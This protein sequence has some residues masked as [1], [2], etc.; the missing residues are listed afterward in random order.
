M[1]YC[2]RS[3]V[4][5]ILF[6]TLSAG[7]RTKTKDN[8]HK[9]GFEPIATGTTLPLER[10]TLAIMDHPQRLVRFIGNRRFAKTLHQCREEDSLVWSVRSFGWEDAGSDAEA[11]TL[12]SLVG[13]RDGEEERK[14][15]T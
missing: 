14:A 13:L 2:Q 5:S 12:V 3:L 11:T 15:Q 1:P 9:F 10:N 7:N 4:S 8:T 6:T